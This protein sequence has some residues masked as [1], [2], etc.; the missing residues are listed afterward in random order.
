MIGLVSV[1]QGVTVG[2]ASGNAGGCRGIFLGGQSRRC[3]NGRGCVDVDVYR[4]LN[5]AINTGHVVLERTLALPS[6]GNKHDITV[7]GMKA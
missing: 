5:G 4:A 3:G 1:N 2:I 6:I 7:G